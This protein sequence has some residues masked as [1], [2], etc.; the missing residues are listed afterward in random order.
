MSTKGFLSPEATKSGAGRGAREDMEGDGWVG[1]SDA[2]D[3]GGAGVG[4]LEGRLHEHHGDVVAVLEEDVGQLRHG[5]HV[6][7]AGAG[8]QDYGLLHRSCPCGRSLDLLNNIAN[9]DV[10]VALAA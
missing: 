3:G 2:L 8:V 9:T 10:L 5:A 7:A 4:R 6:A 1:G